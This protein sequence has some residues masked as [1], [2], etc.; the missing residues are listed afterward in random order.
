VKHWYTTIVSG[1]DD[2]GN[3]TVCTQKFF[4]DEQ[5]LLFDLCGAF[6][7][8]GLSLD[9][10]AK[11]YIIKHSVPMN[12]DKGVRLMMAPVKEADQIILGALS[13]GVGG[14]A[15]AVTAAGYVMHM[16]NVLAKN[17][18]GAY[19]NEWTKA[20]AVAPQDVPGSQGDGET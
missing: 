20:Q 8:A 3:Y 12:D 10:Q 9:V 1:Q 2:G 19:M 7:N 6:L 16:T 15:N 14:G 4:I 11:A 18:M 13:A 5:R 17:A